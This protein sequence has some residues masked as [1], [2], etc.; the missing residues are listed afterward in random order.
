MLRVESIFFFFT[1]GMQC[2]SLQSQGMTH[3][4]F[5][6]PPFFFFLFRKL[7]L[8]TFYFIFLLFTILCTLLF[9]SAFHQKKKIL[10]ALTQVRVLFCFLS[11][12]LTHSNKL[13]HTPFLVLSPKFI[14]L[15]QG[16]GCAENPLTHQT[17][18][19]PTRSAGLGRFLRL[20]RLGWVTKIFFMA[21]W[22]GF[23][24]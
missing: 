6:Y 5:N 9:L 20:G 16:Q 8:N 3:M 14:S 2:R 1:F 17:Q 12:S 4:R 11:L 7:H 18:P 23:G 13:T 19:N 24:S 21:G 10:Q 22:V 15:I